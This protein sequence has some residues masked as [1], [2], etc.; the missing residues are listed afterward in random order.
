[1]SNELTTNTP[2]NAVETAVT[3]TAAPAVATTP[4]NPVVATL[5]EYGVDSITAGMIQAELGI[6][7][8]EELALMNEDDLVGRGMK[9]A[10][11]R[12]MLAALKK[13]DVNT[14][15]TAAFDGQLQKLLPNI[16][17]EDS[18]LTALKTNGVLKVEKSTVIA[19]IRAAIADQA[20]LFDIPNKLIHA[21][22]CYADKTEEQ[23][24]ATIYFSLRKAI[25]RRNYGDLFAAIEGCDGSYVTDKR[26]K[27]FLERVRNNLLPAIGDSFFAL[28]N[29]YE[30]WSTSMNTPSVLLMAINGLN[31]TS[32]VPAIAPPDITPLHAAGETLNNSINSVFKGTGVQIAAAL[33][34]DANEIC[35]TLKDT[36]LPV[37]TGFG[38]YELMLK[39]LDIGV[40]SSYAYQE[41]N[42]IRYVLGFIEHASVTADAAQ[43]YFVAL[44]QLGSQIQWDAFGIR[45]FG[46]ANIGK[47]TSIT[48]KA[49]L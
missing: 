6:D 45:D 14:N 7:T 27:E 49:I 21:M 12:K 25:T 46:K 17:T 1:M 31:G 2:E 39:N 41:E 4:H 3:E 22:E 13:T 28:N 32:G 15:N 38:S 5:V 44:W 26:R 19:A 20:G 35:K 36:R 16:P 9:L 48:G 11:A 24:D 47:H 23:V 10:K 42:L 8:M 18:W 43:S 34:Y 33:A 40:S 37:L 30:N 29:W